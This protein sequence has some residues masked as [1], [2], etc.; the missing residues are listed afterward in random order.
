MKNYTS[1]ASRACVKAKGHGKWR[2]WG[3]I[4][5][6]KIQQ[7]IV[8]EFEQK[9]QKNKQLNPFRIPFSMDGIKR[10][11]FSSFSCSTKPHFC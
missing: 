10:F 6:E 1:P 2:K 8:E 3:I 5:G 11:L 4:D 9:R 7:N